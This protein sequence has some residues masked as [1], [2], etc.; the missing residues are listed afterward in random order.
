MM[1]NIPLDNLLPP[2]YNPVNQTAYEKNVDEDEY[3][4]KRFSES[5]AEVM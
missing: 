4:S 3:V 2:S 5:Q 1:R